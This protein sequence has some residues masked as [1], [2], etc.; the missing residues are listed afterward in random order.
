MHY[1]RQVDIHEAAIQPYDVAHR[2]WYDLQMS[3]TS[4]HQQLLLESTMMELEMLRNWVK[5][6]RER[7]QAMYNT[8]LRQPIT[9]PSNV[10]PPDAR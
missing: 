5:L 7:L 3:V 4:V 8:S 10:H 2:T 1:T 9:M 6:A